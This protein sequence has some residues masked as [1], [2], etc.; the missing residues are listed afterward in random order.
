[1]GSD[2]RTG[3]WASD[4][5]PFPSEDG[6]PAEARERLA[7]SGLAIPEGCHPQRSSPHRGHVALPG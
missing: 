4:Y 3:S 6:L 2:H 1:M 5:G 7:P